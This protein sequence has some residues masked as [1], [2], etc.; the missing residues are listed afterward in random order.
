MG[1]VSP[2]PDAGCKQAKQPLA[3]SPLACSAWPA[4]QDVREEGLLVSLS[5]YNTNGL[6]RNVQ[7]NM[8]ETFV[9][10]RTKQEEAT[11]ERLYLPL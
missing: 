6:F 11:K 2:I 10:S 7:W 3:L 1:G 5:F 4:L 8:F 9:P